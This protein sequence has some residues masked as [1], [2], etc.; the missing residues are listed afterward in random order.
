MDSLFSIVLVLGKLFGHREMV[1]VKRPFLPAIKDSFVLVIWRLSLTSRPLGLLSRDS[2]LCFIVCVWV[3]KLAPLSVHPAPYL[4]AVWIFHSLFLQPSNVD[5]IMYMQSPP[6]TVV[7][8]HRRFVLSNCT[9]TWRFFGF[10]F[11]PKRR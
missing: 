9:T 10:V 11:E 1:V 3:G 4:P 8:I 2:S 6:A 7:A 5:D